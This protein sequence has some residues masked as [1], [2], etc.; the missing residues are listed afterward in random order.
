MG[1]QVPWGSAA[2]PVR[3]DVRASLRVMTIMAQ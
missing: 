1:F 3:P 2:V